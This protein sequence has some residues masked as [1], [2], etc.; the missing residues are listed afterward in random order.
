MNY[1]EQVLEDCINW[2]YLNLKKTGT[3]ANMVLED[4]INW[5]YL[6]FV[7]WVVKFV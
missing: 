1:M 4:C 7:Y 5:Y 6:N 3:L 2:Y